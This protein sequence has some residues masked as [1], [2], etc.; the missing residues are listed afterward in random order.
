MIFRQVRARGVFALLFGLMCAWAELV[1]AATSFEFA[2]VEQG[3][4]IIGARDDY[5][6]R[7][8]PLERA[9]KAKSEVPVS[10]AD[11][12]RLLTSA[13]QPWSDAGRA[14]VQAALDSIRPQLAVLN[15]PLPETVV[16]VRFTGVGEGNAPHTRA[17]AVL[18]T[19][20][21]LQRPAA[22]ARLIAHE[23][24]HIASR[25]DKGWR[26]AHVRDDRIRIDRRTSTSATT[27]LSQNYKS[28]RASHRRRNQSRHRRQHRMGR[29]ATAIDRRPLRRFATGR[30]FLVPAALLA[31][32]RTRRA[33]TRKS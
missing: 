20:T 3:R 6:Q 2:T 19:D 7:L 15:L 23:L 32:S 22:L 4:A 27:R 29:A 16:F 11:F 5:V 26:D 9:L 31:T 14:T 8:S 1:H 18:L 13:V 24:F 30:I 25:Q 17:N 28:R 21:S 12:L 33:P 10:E